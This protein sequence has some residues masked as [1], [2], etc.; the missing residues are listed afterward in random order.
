MLEEEVETSRAS[1][2][3]SQSDQIKIVWLDCLQIYA[4]THI[5][6]G[7]VKAHVYAGGKWM[8]SF[9][10]WESAFTGGSTFW[11]EDWDG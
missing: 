2:S 3:T 9:K 1:A 5:L 6:G 7:H 8:P 10:C 4:S 11:C